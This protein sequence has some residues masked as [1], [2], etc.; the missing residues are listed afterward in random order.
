[1]TETKTIHMPPQECPMCGKAFD[2][3]VTRLLSDPPIDQYPCGCE[4]RYAMTW[5]TVWSEEEG[6]AQ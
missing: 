4:L 2:G 1:V 6:W 5:K 3:R